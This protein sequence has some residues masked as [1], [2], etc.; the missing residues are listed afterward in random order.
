ME[1]KAAMQEF[2]RLA[3]KQTMKHAF[4]KETSSYENQ[5]ERFYKGTQLANIHPLGTSVSATEIRNTMFQEKVTLKSKV[6]N[7]MKLDFLE[8]NILHIELLCIIS[9]Q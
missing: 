4:T 6:F 1:T 8:G 7:M 2:C 5:F 9:A 3:K